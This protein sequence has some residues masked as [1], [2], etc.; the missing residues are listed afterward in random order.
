MLIVQKFGGSS[1]ADP[2]RL[3]RAAGICGEARRRGNKLV[4]VVSAAGDTTDALLERAH[5]IHPHPPLR[6]LDA[7]AATGEQQS[8]ALMAIM[9]ESLGLSARSFSG[10]QAG[11]HTDAG[12]GEA[13]I[14][15]IDPSRLTEAMNADQIA[16]VAGFQGLSPE[17]DVTTLGRGGSDTTAVALA[18]ALGADRCEIY[19][20][21]DGIYTADPRLLPDARLLPEIDFRD[22][23]LLAEAGSQVLHPG[24]VRLAMERGLPVRLLSSFRAG[25]GSL[26]RAMAEEE[27]PSL[28]GVTRDEG[29][30]TVTL[31]GRDAD[32][33]LLAQMQNRLERSGIPVRSMQAGE[34]CATL[35]VAPAQLLPAL[36]L[37]HRE[38]LKQTERS[39]ES[40]RI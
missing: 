24:S 27:R 39:S 9:L 31:V 10:W 19:T 32:E 2:R 18:I 25:E 29:R 38:V 35:T 26:V 5:Q 34:G 12:H 7:L 15:Q 13:A 8:A 30:S 20:D 22:M 40:N 17:A 36:E 4:V 28:A 21:V 14:L 33:A 37:C 1:L 11:I 16:V 6:E 23:L 3:R